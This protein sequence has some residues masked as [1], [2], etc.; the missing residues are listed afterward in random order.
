MTGS[1]RAKREARESA[2]QATIATQKLQEQTTLL[3]ERSDAEKTRA[4]RLLMR[5]M[6]AAGGGYFESASNTLGSTGV[7][8]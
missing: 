1:S 6:R 5:S 7:L 4:Q 3:K 2:Q 8:G